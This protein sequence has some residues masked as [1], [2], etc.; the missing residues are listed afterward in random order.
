[1]RH[2]ISIDL[3]TS[4]IVICDNKNGVILDEPSVIAFHTTNNQEKM[5][6][7]GDDAKLMLGKTPGSI[8]A[9]QPLSDGVIADFDAAQ[10]MITAF[11]A[12]VVRLSKWRKPIVYVCVPYGA[13]AVEKRAIKATIEAAGGKDVGLVQ[14]PMAAALGAGLKVLSPRGSMVIDIGGGTSEI[15]VLSL[16]GV[17]VAR[18]ERIGGRHFDV[19]ISNYI[20][21]TYNLHVGLASC[22][23]MKHSI[24]SVI[25]PPDGQ[26]EHVVLRGRHALTG[27]PEQQKVTQ[28]DIATALAP[29]AQQLSEAILKILEQ[30]PPDLA[31]DIQEDGMMITGGGA[32]L[33]GLEE[34]IKSIT[35][36]HAVKADNNKHSVALGTQ[37]AMNL[38]R[39]FEHA[40][41][42]NP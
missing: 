6:A 30:T 27:L 14:E 42:R 34:L 38:G 21:K 37:M 31:G 15:A 20:K 4:N 33:Q 22:E 32:G 17:V 18:S 2:K 41:E 26:G 28:A 7:V 23:E 3:G 25:M 39:Q 11:F 12:K 24:G 29:L 10:S 5:L 1:M 40:I 36:I 35:G 13:T 8:R 9:V 16:G 19:V